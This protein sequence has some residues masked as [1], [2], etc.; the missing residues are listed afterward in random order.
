M[1]RPIAES[2]CVHPL[3]AGSLVRQ[4]TSLDQQ[5]STR[6]PSRV[7]RCWA[8]M[9]GLSLAGDLTMLRLRRG[10]ICTLKR[11]QRRTLFSLDKT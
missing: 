10:E 2:D 7:G 5:G 8:A 1:G 3:E 6:E 4:D 11:A 9:S